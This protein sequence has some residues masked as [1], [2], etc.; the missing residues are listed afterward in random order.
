MLKI[1]KEAFFGYMALE[2]EFVL[3]EQY[4]RNGLVESIKYFFEDYYEGRKE[5]AI[6]AEQFVAIVEEGSWKKAPAT[7]ASVGSG[8]NSSGGLRQFEYRDDKSAKF[9]NIAVDGSDMTVTFGKI[10]TAGQTQIKSFDSET[11]CQKQAEKLV[12]EKTK[13]GYVEK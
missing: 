11:E 3:K 5:A 8:E 4:T 9:W 12:R 2:S 7:V 13:K 6:L 10:G 1:Y